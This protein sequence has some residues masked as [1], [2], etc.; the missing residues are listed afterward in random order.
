[1]PSFPIPA[2]LHNIHLTSNLQGLSRCRPGRTCPTARCRLNSVRRPARRPHPDFRY[3]ELHVKTPE[4]CQD[5]EECK[6][7]ANL[8]SGSEEFR[9][10][11]L[12]SNLWVCKERDRKIGHVRT[13]KLNWFQVPNKVTTK[14]MYFLVCKVECLTK[15]K[16]CM[17]MK[18]NW[19]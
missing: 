3:L 12:S 2:A 8:C 9:D 17:N 16:S 4:S 5:F 19:S 13:L 15:I 18:W 6:N 7:L 11:H 14:I 10:S 1:V